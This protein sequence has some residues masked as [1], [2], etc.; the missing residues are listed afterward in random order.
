MSCLLSSV[1]STLKGV[2]LIALCSFVGVRLLSSFY[3]PGAAAPSTASSLPPSALMIQGK[4][5]NK[6]LRKKKCVRFDLVKNTLHTYSPV[7]CKFM[8][9]FAKN[10]TWVEY[11]HEEDPAGYDTLHAQKTKYIRDWPSDVDV[12]DDD[13]DIDMDDS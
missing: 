9:T 1:V 7:P 11:W 5:C 2:G 13:G 12:V 6:L 8:V 10:K 4:G 3:K